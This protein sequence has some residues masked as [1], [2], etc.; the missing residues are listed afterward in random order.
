[1]KAADRYLTAI[2]SQAIVWGQTQKE[3]KRITIKQKERKEK[4]LAT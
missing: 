2:D 1:V 4:Q 3:K